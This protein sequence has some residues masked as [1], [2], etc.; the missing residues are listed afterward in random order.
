[1]VGCR[2]QW[3]AVFSGQSGALPY[4]TMPARTQSARTPASAAWRRVAALLLRL[5]SPGRSC[6]AVLKAA[7]WW[8]MPRGPSASLKCVMYE[9][10]STCGSAFSR[11]QAAR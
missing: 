3:A 1:M 2:P 4:T 6:V 7:I 10:S 8:A 9:I 11:A 5:R